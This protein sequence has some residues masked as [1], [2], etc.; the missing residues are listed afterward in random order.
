MA[1]KVQAEL[2]AFKIITDNEVG[3]IHQ[4]TLQVL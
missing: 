2:P 4:A 1:V 3:A